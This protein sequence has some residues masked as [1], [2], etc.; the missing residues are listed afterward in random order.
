MMRYRIVGHVGGGLR[1]SQVAGLSPIA[2]I[3]ARVYLRSQIRGGGPGQQISRVSHLASIVARLFHRSQITVGGGR[4][5]IARAHRG[6]GVT[7]L[8]D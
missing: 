1:V 2:C 5:I 3:K 4:E 6:S 8:A 7:P